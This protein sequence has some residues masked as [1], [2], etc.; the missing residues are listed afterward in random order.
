MIETEIP[1]DNPILTEQVQAETPAAQTVVTPKKK[2][3]KILLL[4]GLGIFFIVLLIFSAIASAVAQQ[5]LKAS[6]VIKPSL[7]TS[8]PAPIINPVEIPTTWSDK[9]SPIK[10]ELDKL[11]SSLGK[12]DFLPPVFDNSIGL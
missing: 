5:K 10:V 4:A 2:D 9:L 7:P 8:T 11:N 3:K 12:D 1:Q 6:A